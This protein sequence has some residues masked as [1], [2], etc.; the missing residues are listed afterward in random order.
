MG[1]NGADCQRGV[2]FRSGGS[3]DWTM[4]APVA[5]PC[6]FYVY[7]CV[8]T[9]VCVNVCMHGRYSTEFHMFFHI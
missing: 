7:V 9:Y 2:P 6:A 1:L 5:M 4:A 8:F 3:G